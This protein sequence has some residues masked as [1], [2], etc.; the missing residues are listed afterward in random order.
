MEGHCESSWGKDTIHSKQWKHSAVRCAEHRHAQPW[1]FLCKGFTFFSF[2]FTF[3]P[4]LHLLKKSWVPSSACFN[5]F[6]P[7]SGAPQ[8]GDVLPGAFRT[9]YQLLHLCPTLVAISFLVLHTCFLSSYYELTFLR[10]TP[11]RAVHLLLSAP[12]CFFPSSLWRVAS[13]H[14]SWLFA[15]L[16]S[17]CIPKGDAAKCDSG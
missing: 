9:T 10:L 16:R 4:P 3:L 14:S 6:T 13:R 5:C 8:Q 11:S 1:L 12:L 7:L 2:S 15:S 17:F